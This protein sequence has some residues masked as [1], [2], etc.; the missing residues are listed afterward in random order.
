MALFTIPVAIRNI[1][2]LRNHCYYTRKK[3]LVMC[4]LLNRFLLE[5][6]VEALEKNSLRC[7]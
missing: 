6:Q 4:I 2:L 3:G 1:E 7:L 5:I